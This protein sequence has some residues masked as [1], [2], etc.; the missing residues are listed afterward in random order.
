MV[1]GSKVRMLHGVGEGIVTKVD[2]NQLVVLLNQG[3]EIPMRRQDVVEVAARQ[4][5]KSMPK[6]DLSNLRCFGKPVGCFL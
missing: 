3:L 4:E 6:E 5:E 2:G 1:V